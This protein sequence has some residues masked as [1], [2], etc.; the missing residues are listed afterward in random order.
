MSPYCVGMG[1]VASA[2]V[3]VSARFDALSAIE[4]PTSEIE[5]AASGV[6]EGASLLAAA[7]SCSSVEA[8]GNDSATKTWEWKDQLAVECSK[9]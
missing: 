8:A 9:D 2:A 6:L 7:T 5:D 3:A 1:F 4:E